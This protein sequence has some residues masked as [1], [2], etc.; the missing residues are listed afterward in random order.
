MLVFGEF[1]FFQKVVLDSRGVK[2]R[3]AHEEQ[4]R[5]KNMA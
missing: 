2:D 1:I 3:V 4:V 5:L